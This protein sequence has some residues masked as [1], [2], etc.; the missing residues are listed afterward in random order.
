M[1]H[2]IAAQT[3]FEDICWYYKWKVPEREL[4]KKTEAENQVKRG[5]CIIWL[6]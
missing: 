2:K 5:L 3:I 1:K 4:R 6:G